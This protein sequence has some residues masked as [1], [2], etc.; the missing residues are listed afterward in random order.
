MSSTSY[1]GTF[2]KR[3]LLSFI[4]FFLEDGPLL[5]SALPLPAMNSCADSDVKY[6]MLRVPRL[7][8]P[9]LKMME[10][11]TLYPV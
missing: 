1:S 9:S 3:I 8:E 10:S 11:S 6:V 2:L 7:M 4:F 5:E